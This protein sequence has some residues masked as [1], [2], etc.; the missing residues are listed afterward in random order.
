VLDFWSH[1]VQFQAAV[2]SMVPFL[3]CMGATFFFQFKRYT[4]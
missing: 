1:P 3:W 4:T 2:D